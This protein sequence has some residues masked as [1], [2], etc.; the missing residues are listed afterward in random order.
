MSHQQA[1]GLYFGPSELHGLGVYC[2]NL[3]KGGDLIELAPVIVLENMTIDFLR[4]SVLY[5]YYFLWGEKPALG[6]G[7]ASLY[8]HSSVPNAEFVLDFGERL[9][10]FKALQEIPPGTEITTDY[11]SGRPDLDVWFDVVPASA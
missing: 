10:Q 4:N 7:Y 1:P 11:H 9:I 3:L 5:N 8:N 2:S 6:L